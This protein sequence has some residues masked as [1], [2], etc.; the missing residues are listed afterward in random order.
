MQC[1][2]WLFLLPAR[3]SP[4][5]REKAA[6]NHNS[7]LN[8]VPVQP[9]KLVKCLVSC[10]DFNSCLSGRGLHMWEMLLLWLTLYWQPELCEIL[11]GCS[12]SVQYQQTAD[13]TGMLHTQT[14]DKHRQC[15]SITIRLL[16]GLFGACVWGLH[17]FPSGQVLK[18]NDSALVQLTV[19]GWDTCQSRQTYVCLSLK[20]T[21]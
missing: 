21:A 11:T 7:A 13:A 17:S 15:L 10:K 20:T 19:I 16:K 4:L 18:P 9:L 1:N 8:S 14:V 2:Q 5:S 6:T 12:N 3:T